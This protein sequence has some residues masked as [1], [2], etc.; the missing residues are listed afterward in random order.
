MSIPFPAPDATP[1]QIEA[2]LEQVG[3]KLTVP[4]RQPVSLGETHT[5]L[6]LREP[7]AAEWSQWSHLRG[8]DSDIK[9]VS[10]ISGVPEAAV[11]MIGSR[12]LIKA[13]RFIAL[14]LD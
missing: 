10:V 7:T 12:D 11:R 5:V 14:F 3:Y 2:Y 6:E 4:L 13:S 8:V 9:A 1:E